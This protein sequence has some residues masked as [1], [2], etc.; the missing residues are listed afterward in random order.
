MSDDRR[1]IPGPNLNLI[2]LDPLSDSHQPPD[3]ELEY[4]SRAKDYGG[5]VG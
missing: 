2:L 5:R 3:A 1:R 4:R